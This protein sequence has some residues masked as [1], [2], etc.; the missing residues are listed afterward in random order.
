M[1]LEHHWLDPKEP[2]ANMFQPRSPLILAIREGDIDVFRLLLARGANVNALCEGRLQSALEVASE[3]RADTMF[4]ALLE[5]GADSA[6]N[7]SAAVVACARVGNTAGLI[8]LM[9]RGANIHIQQGVPGKAL[10]E[11]AQNSQL[12][13]VKLLLE[14]G[15]DVNSTG[16]KDG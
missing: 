3:M 12:G 11:A 4:N 13:T 14:C 10:H 6:L 2:T 8:A 7:D 5:N 9:D 16:G 15:V 1:R